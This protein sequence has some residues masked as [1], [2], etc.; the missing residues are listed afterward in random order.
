[1]IISDITRSGVQQH[2]RLLRFR[3]RKEGMSDADWLA[4]QTFLKDLGGETL[5]TS[6]TQEGVATQMAL[7]QNPKALPEEKGQARERLTNGLFSWVLPVVL[8]H[9]RRGMELSDLLQESYLKLRTLFMSPDFPPA[10]PIQDMGAWVRSVVQRRL[11]DVQKKKVDPCW[12]E[13]TPALRADAR[14]DDPAAEAAAYEFK[15]AMAK[16]EQAIHDAIPTLSPS[17]QDYLYR[18]AIDQ[19]VAAMTQDLGKNDEA[20]V[21]MGLSRARRRL[22]DAVEKPAKECMAYSAQ[23]VDASE[24]LV[25]VLAQ[26]VAL[27]QGFPSVPSFQYLLGIQQGL[28]EQ[29]RGYLQ[30][31]P[32]KELSSLTR[33]VSAQRRT[34][35]APVNGEV[36]PY[37]PE[38]SLQT[39]APTLARFVEAG[40]KKMNAQISAREIYWTNVLD[41]TVRLM[42]LAQAKAAV[43]E[44]QIKPVQLGAWVEQALSGLIP[45]HRK[46]LLH[47]VEGIS[48]EESALRLKVTTEGARREIP[49]AWNQL[50]RQI[51]RLTLGMA[52][53]YADGD[54]EEAQTVAAMALS[55][56]VCR[57]ARQTLTDASTRQANVRQAVLG[58]F[59]AN[60]AQSQMLIARALAQVPPAEFDL[61]KRLAKGESLE[62]MRGQF[63]R[64]KHS[65]TARLHQARTSFRQSLADVLKEPSR[66]VAT[67][68][69][70][71]E[72]VA[73]EPMVDHAETQLSAAFAQVS[74]HEQRWQCHWQE[75]L[76]TQQAVLAQLIDKAWLGLFPFEKRLLREDVADTPMSWM[77]GGQ[78]RKTKK[79]ACKAA[80]ATYRR[81]ILTSLQQQMT[82]FGVQELSAQPTDR[83]WE[84]VMTLMQPLLVDQ[85]NDQATQEKPLE[86]QFLKTYDAKQAEIDS[87][88]KTTFT[89]LPETVK[90]VVLAAAS[91]KNRLLASQELGLNLRKAANQF[92]R[93]KAAFSTLVMARIPEGDW[94]DGSSACAR[95][96]DRV[97][98]RLMLE[99][100]RRWAE[101][102]G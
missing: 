21:H 28:A 15:R 22:F 82:R 1:M 10:V 94:A 25:K 6:L 50:V 65:M 34:T 87:A 81:V 46:L 74:A 12:A 102:K 99:S 41:K 49:R 72:K 101:S 83:D 8:H 90:R 100:V 18:D 16:L 75:Q 63:E 55:L 36:H 40:A 73:L 76:K 78:P 91:G 92:S 24:T 20:A 98:E 67:S 71:P 4:Y 66:I 86:L 96:T 54:E 2:K 68:L 17:D 57:H 32:P 45:F 88:W 77:D 5:F 89:S 44:P 3:G 23:S 85:I 43:L 31:L 79:L 52:K 47:E 38:T 61:L 48:P 64:T 14:T 60:A 51:D 13:T 26:K 11:L 19:P 84:A 93:A 56:L 7:L 27:Q 62:T 58:W 59:E 53:S 35:F 97:L 95:M 33:A 42:I 80:W 29:V 37:A 70:M 30:E 69:S 39:L 9:R